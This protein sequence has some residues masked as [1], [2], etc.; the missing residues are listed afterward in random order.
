MCNLQ[1]N[2]PVFSFLYFCLYYT[3]LFISPLNMS[4]N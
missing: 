2:I 4:E 3:D 1:R